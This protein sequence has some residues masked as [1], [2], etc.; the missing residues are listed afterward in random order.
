MG[1]LG[2]MNSASLEAMA[3]S[4]EIISYVLR[5]KK[6]IRVN[7][8]TANMGVFKEVGP[9]GNFLTTQH[10]LDHFRKEMWTPMGFDRSSIMVGED[11]ASSHFENHTKHAIREALAAHQPPDLPEDCD[12]RLDEI[13]HG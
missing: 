7:E 6:G 4:S 1:L 3:V 2:G 9:L 13:I 8:D 5:I 11:D 12:K 10:T